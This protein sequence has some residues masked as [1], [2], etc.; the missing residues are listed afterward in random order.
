M[1]LNHAFKKIDQILT[2]T[3]HIP[4][5]PVPALGKMNK[6][7]LPVPVLL[8]LLV[9]VLPIG[10][11]VGPL[12]MTSL[13][14]FLIAVIMPLIV[15]LLLGKYG[16]VLLIDVLFILH[17]VWAT[18]ALVVNSPDR[19]VENI[20]AAAIEFLGGY[21][22]GRAYIR[23]PEAFG[24]L[25]RTLMLIV[26]CSLPF[27]LFETLTGRPLIIE[28]IRK[29]PGLTSYAVNHSTARLGLERVQLVFAHPIHYGLFCSVIFSLFYVGMWGQVG[30]ARRVLSGMLIV[31]CG[32]LALSS[33]V[34][35]A[36]LLQIGLIFWAWTFDGIKMRW[37]LLVGL[38]VMAYISIDLLSNRTPIKVFMS[39]ATFSAHTAYWRGIIFD[40]GLANVIGSAEKGVIG[41]PLFGIGLNDWVR[42]HY[43][44]SGSMDNF[45]LVMAVRYGLPGVAFIALGYVIGLARVMRRNFENDQVLV[46][47]RRAWVFTF[48]GLSFTLSTVHV[49][50]S[51]YSFIFFIFGAG[52]WLITA[53]PKNDSDIVPIVGG[54]KGDARQRANR[55]YTRFPNAARSQARA[56][57]RFVRR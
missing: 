1:E 28:I 34:L 47:F 53:Q 36:I 15:R 22:V 40:W 20:G 55:K 46:Q 23:T 38:F 43:M 42:P 3:E 11:R 45:W 35:L 29:I 31:A 13:R 25:C 33:G 19:V 48:L 57:H 4:K 30:N 24:A 52:I 12:Y 37:W 10:F 32:F 5:L 49:W 21:V 56:P 54:E 2:A 39:Y 6:D 16:K 44:Y 8:Y 27:I 51:I 50:T 14:L 17:I 26:L 7:R 9:I 41:S 18:I